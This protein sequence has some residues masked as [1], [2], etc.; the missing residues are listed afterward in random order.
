VKPTTELPDDPALPGLVA[1]RAKGLAGA[2]PALGLDGG[3]VE[4]VLCGYTPGRRA[5]LD[6]RTGEQR[7]A[8]KVYADDPAQ[9]GELYEALAV[10]G[11]LAPPLLVFDRDLRVLVIGWLEGPTAQELVKAGQGARA[12]ELAARW[13]CRMRAI[14]VKLGPP[15]GA[16]DMLEQTVEWVAA[17]ADAD[18][19]LGAVA[20]KLVRTLSVARPRESAP[21]LVHGTL[22]A[23]HVLDHRD[24]PAVID[25]NRFGQGP[26]ELDAGM[27]L[28]TISRLGLFRESVAGEAARAE[29]AFLA[30]TASFL[31]ARAIAWY[32]AVALLRFSQKRLP[33][34]RRKRDWMERAQA[35]LGEAA[36]VAEGAL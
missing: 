11:P 35:L 12:G 36:R 1:I 23:R 24:G 26:A 10:D 16:A 8:I 13:L 4:T 2:I 30:G 31:V 29:E 33:T 27:F 32:R 7:V 3:P 34:R 9:E 18:P 15:L 6:A 21:G 20:T 5:T 22:Y 14:G 25:W 28:A 19:S 17:L